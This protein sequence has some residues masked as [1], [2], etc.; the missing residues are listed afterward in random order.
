M[1]DEEKVVSLGAAREKFKQ[2]E[3][4]EIIEQEEHTPEER[5]YCSF[6]K[7]P[8]DMVLKMIKGPDVNICS[9]CV[10]ICTQYMML[11]PGQSI[12]PQVQNMLSAFWS[13]VE[14]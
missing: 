6:C 13:G 7:R 1:S 9:E 3:A 5:V 11:E 4:E 10:L 12:S 8:N 2:E 14:K